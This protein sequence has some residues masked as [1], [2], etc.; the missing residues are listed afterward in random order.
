MLD[1][2]CIEK[3][4]MPTRH[5]LEASF[6][7]I[8]NWDLSNEVKRRL[9]LD[10][11]MVNRL[12]TA[13]RAGSSILPEG[14]SVDLEVRFDGLCHIIAQ[15]YDLGNETEERLE[16]QYFEPLSEGPEPDETEILFN[17]ETVFLVMA[18]EIVVDRLSTSVI[19]D[20]TLS[21][22]FPDTN[23]SIVRKPRE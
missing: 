5:D 7:R 3:I 18:G 12:I 6:R 11:P 23:V 9:Y 22:Y 2:F 8:E 16:F 15:M 21:S 10:I 14:E 1:K 19:L 4:V 20:K 13:R 17:G